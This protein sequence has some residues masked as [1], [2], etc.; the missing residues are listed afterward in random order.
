MLEMT[1]KKIIWINTYF[2]NTHF[3]IE[4]WKHE[5]CPIVD[6]V[7]KETKEKFWQIYEQD[8]LGKNRKLWAEI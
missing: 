7:R 2:W 3:I 1:S 4:L 8:I 5:Y 6:A